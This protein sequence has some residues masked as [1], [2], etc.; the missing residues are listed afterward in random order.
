[1]GPF[2]SSEDRVVNPQVEDGHIDIANEI[3]EKL[4]KVNLSPY[5]W[6]LL[7]AIWRKTWGWH[8]KMDSISGSQLR[9]LTGN[10]CKQHLYRARKKL[11]AKNIIVTQ[12]D[13]R[14]IISY[15]FQK[16][17]DKWK[18]SPKEVTGNPNRLPRSPK[19]VT[20]GNLKRRTQKKRKKL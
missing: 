14:G 8:K 12:I 9:E 13:Y 17:F 6:R 16:D 5:E 1:L 4:A 3:A 20:G 2:L 10:L 11:L 19:E 15:G 7:W 18:V